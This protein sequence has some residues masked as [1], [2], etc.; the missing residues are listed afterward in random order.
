MDEVERLQLL[1]EQQK[2]TQTAPH[3][4]A[5]QPRAVS[6]STLSHIGLWLAVLILIALSVANWIRT[7][8]NTELIEELP[9]RIWRE[10]YTL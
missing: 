5:G 1:A 10:L 3:A 2:S 7:S 8:R 9:Q 4:P 6:I